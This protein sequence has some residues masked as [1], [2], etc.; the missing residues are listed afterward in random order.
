[1]A[2]EFNMTTSNGNKYKVFNYRLAETLCEEVKKM[3][4][5]YKFVMTQKN[6]DGS[7]N[8]YYGQSEN[9]VA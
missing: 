7:V 9:Y 3:G 2:I 5:E 6:N 4:L 1:M 8:V